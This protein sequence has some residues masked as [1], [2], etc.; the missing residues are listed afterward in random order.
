M[1]IDNTKRCQF[2]FGKSAR[3]FNMNVLGFMLIRIKKELEP[4]LE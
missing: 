2:N 1:I 4:F 3:V